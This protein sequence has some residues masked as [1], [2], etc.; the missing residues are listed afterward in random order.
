MA[1]IVKQFERT[2]QRRSFYDRRVR[3]TGYSRVIS[4]SKVIPEDWTYVRITPLGVTP[5]S[6]QLLI[7][8]LMGA[9]D[10]AQSKTN[11]KRGKQDT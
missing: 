10:T 4:L 5:D 2:S 11:N 3:R 1:K 9:D 8:K 6:V 7:E